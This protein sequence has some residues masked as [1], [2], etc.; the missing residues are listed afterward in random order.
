MDLEMITACGIVRPPSQTCWT[1]PYRGLSDGSQANSAIPLPS[2]ELADV[3]SQECKMD[4]TKLEANGAEE[5]QR[6]PTSH[7]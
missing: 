4:E 7:R 6:L 5:D 2:M 1:E 3:W